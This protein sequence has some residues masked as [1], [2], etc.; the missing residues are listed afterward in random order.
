MENLDFKMQDHQTAIE[1][2][3]AINYFKRMKE[4]TGESLNGMARM[5]PNLKKKYEHQTIIYTM[6]ISRMENRYTN[7]V[8]KL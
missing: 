6:C 7:L 4:L 2:L 5:F 1:I 8:N 3:S